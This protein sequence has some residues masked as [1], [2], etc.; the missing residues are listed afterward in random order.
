[1]TERIARVLAEHRLRRDQQGW[2]CACLEDRYPNTLGARVI[3][4]THEQH[5]ASIVLATALGAEG[6]KR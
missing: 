4:R 5:V 2:T 1:M 3:T 6:S